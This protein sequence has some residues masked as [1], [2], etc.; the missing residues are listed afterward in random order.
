MLVIVLVV[1]WIRWSY[2]GKILGKIWSNKWTFKS[3]SKLQ[4]FC[5]IFIY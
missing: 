1:M 4:H 3:T 5:F 2:F